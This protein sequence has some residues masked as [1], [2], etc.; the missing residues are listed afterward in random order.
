[1][2]K[3]MYDPAIQVVLLWDSCSGPMAEL[4]ESV[5][6]F[7]EKGNV[8]GVCDSTN[9]KNHCCVFVGRQV[10]E[11]GSPERETWYKHPQGQP[12]ERPE[13]VEGAEGEREIGRD[14]GSGELV[15][16]VPHPP[17]FS[18]L[19]LAGI[20]S[21]F[22][23]CSDDG[24]TLVP[25]QFKYVECLLFINLCTKSSHNSTSCISFVEPEVHRV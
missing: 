8:K 14:M 23:P 20:P 24:R 2:I 13:T 12:Q 6:H 4:Q 22:S 5:G 9:V 18:I 21:L 3:N 10:A 11:D 17:L 1:M 25:L 16:R 15:R 19:F 7:F